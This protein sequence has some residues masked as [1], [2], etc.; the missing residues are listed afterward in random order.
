VLLVQNISRS[1]YT[2][3]SDLAAGT[4]YWRVRAQHGLAYGPWS[5][6]VNFR[7]VAP[8]PTP[9]GL[10]LFWMLNQPSSVSGGHSTQA[11]VSLNAPAPPG[12]ATVRIASDMPHAEAPQSVFIP[13]GKTDATVSPIT[14]I[15]VSVR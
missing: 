8:P 3:V 14:T 11:R 1:D 6:G 12:G 13:E 2:L 9:P 7:V 15:P 4:Y 10:N 5:S